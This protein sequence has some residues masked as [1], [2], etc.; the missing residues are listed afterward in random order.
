MHFC[1]RE[2]LTSLF[3]CTEKQAHIS[4]TLLVFLFF[5]LVFFWFFLFPFI[6]CLCALI[7]PNDKHQQH[8]QCTQI[9]GHSFLDRKKELKVLTNR[10]RTIEFHVEM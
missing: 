4:Q 7:N 2:H 8:A 9:I 10:D 6:V 5:S 3:V 1:Y